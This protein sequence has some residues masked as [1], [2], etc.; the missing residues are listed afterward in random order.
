MNPMTVYGIGAGLGALGSWLGGNAQ[1]KAQKQQM[2]IE[3]ARRVGATQSLQG[4]GYQPYSNS[5]LAQYLSG[6]L[7]GAE[8]GQIAQNQ[9]IGEASIARRSAGMGMPSGA[10]MGLYG[11]LSRD[12]SLGAGQ[13]AGQKQ[14][15]GLQYSMADW[16]RQQEAEMQKKQL[17]AQYSPGY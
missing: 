7:S 15:I 16:V 8:Q 9:R 3:Q 1:A 17:L 12:I 13:L 2:A 5:I 4:Y 6:Q 10:Q 11:Q 14:Q